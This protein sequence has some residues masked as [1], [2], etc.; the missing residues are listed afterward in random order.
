MGLTN[1]REAVQKIQGL[2]AYKRK[3]RINITLPCTPDN[4]HT[5]S[6]INGDI[7]FFNHNLHEM[8]ATAVLDKLA[9]NKLLNSQAC[10]CVKILRFI[11]ESKNIS[12]VSYGFFPSS[13]RDALMFVGEV[14]ERRATYRKL[15]TEEIPSSK[16]VELKFVSMLKKHFEEKLQ[17][18]KPTKK[19]YD[20]ITG[21]EKDI[22][23]PLT[24]DVALGEPD[25]AGY[26]KE[27]EK[28]RFHEREEDKAIV[29]ITVPLKHFGSLYNKGMA[30]V[31]GCAILARM[32]DFNSTS[33]LALVGKQTYGYKITKEYAIVH[34][35]RNHLSWIS[36]EKAREILTQGKIPRSRRT[37]K[38]LGKV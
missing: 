13:V 27:G 5:I 8:K 1:R 31:D 19:G 18:R 3:K 35:E 16:A 12:E 17:Y 34:P 25:I 2:R 20:P 23:I 33:F 30:V 37:K 24:I 10:S 11:T 38:E 7:Y 14:K 6:F 29:N 28:R 4:I 21:N 15:F 26:L 9:H 32:Y 36:E 22:P